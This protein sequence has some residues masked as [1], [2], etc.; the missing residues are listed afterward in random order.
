MEVTKRI[1]VG[2]E[3]FVTI[4]DKE[5]AVAEEQQTIKDKEEEVVEEEVVEEEVAEEEV[6][7]EEVVEEEVVY[8]MLKGML[9]LLTIKDPEEEVMEEEDV[10][11]LLKFTQEEGVMVGIPNALVHRWRRHS[12]RRLTTL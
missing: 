8:D 1:M 2:E 9:L 11:E 6:V 3:L 5:K 10:E 7:E 4:K 12:Y